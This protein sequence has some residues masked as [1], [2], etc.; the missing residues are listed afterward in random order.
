MRFRYSLCLLPALFAGACSTTQNKASLEPPAPPQTFAML[1]DSVAAVPYGADQ[2]LP[3][4][5][6]LAAVATV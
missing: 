6:A 1:P 3:T 2:P 5:P 4:A